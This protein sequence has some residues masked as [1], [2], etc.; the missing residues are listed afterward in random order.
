MKADNFGTGNPS[1]VPSLLVKQKTFVQ[2]IKK[3]FI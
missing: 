1:P 2:I 3:Q